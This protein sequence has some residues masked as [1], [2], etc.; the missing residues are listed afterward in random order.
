MKKHFSGHTRMFISWQKR[1]L[2]GWLLGLFLLSTLLF[3]CGNGKTSSKDSELPDPL[4]AC[5][6]LTKAEVEAMIGGTV[7]E[8]QETFK[9]DKELN[10]WMSNCNY[11]SAEKNISTGFTIM[12]HG[13]KVN[14][15]KAFALYEAEVKEELGEDFTMEVVDGLGDYAGWMN[16]PNQLTIFQGSF[17][18]VVTLISSDVQEAAAL[19]LSKHVAETVLARLPQ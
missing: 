8:P 17:M 18:L 14:G 19:D 1:Y 13:R 6:L 5:D 12:P 7:D 4:H 16:N 11:Y 15:A 2:N 10:H 3:G 9:E